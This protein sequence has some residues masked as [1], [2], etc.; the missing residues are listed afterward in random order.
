MFWCKAL[1]CRV[2]QAAFRLVLP[3]L[4]YRE[5]E[6]VRAA[7]IVTD[8]GVVS[9]GLTAAVEAALERE[10][11]PYGVYDK[12]RPNPTVDNVE[13]A[14]ALYHAR[15]CDCLIAIPTTAGTGSEVTLAAADFVK[16]VCEDYSR[17]CFQIRNEW[18]V[19]HA[20]RVIAVFNGE[21]SGTRN[22]MEYAT[23]VG[24]PIVCING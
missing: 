5:P 24:V 12:T 6:L 16:Y 1:F 17:S 9:H 22:T 23:K 8:Q 4:P 10:R 13:E 2:F 15:G 21:R 18:M 11:V 19:N 3:I 7:L 14:L 20:A